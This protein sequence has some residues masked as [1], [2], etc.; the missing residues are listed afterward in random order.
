M[1][2]TWQQTPQKTI[3]GKNLG[4]HPW[5]WWDSQRCRFLH[6]FC[7]SSW[8]MK[9]SL[10]A[11][12]PE[13]L[14]PRP[15]W[16]CFEPRALADEMSKKKTRSVSSS[17]F[18]TCFLMLVASFYS[19]IFARSYIVKG[20]K[21]NHLYIYIY[22]CSILKHVKDRNHSWP[23]Y[24]CEV[25]SSDPFPGAALWHGHP[26]ASDSAA[27]KNCPEAQNAAQGGL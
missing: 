3:E 8:T 18:F 1:T 26:P 12:P 2:I 21:Q 22:I 16:R 13:G 15:R 6:D 23:A 19:I 17:M 5:T 7:R 24:A 11:A 10:L 14:L 9:A 20:H 27:S 25:R 4:M